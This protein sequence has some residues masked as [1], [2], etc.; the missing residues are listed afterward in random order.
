VVAD[1]HITR[2]RDVNMK[3][4]TTHRATSPEPFDY[5]TF[6]DPDGTVQLTM[7]VGGQLDGV[8]VST[9]DPGVRWT[10]D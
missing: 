3:K 8:W 2:V 5:P 9:D 1:G 4:P 10:A 7:I 6:D